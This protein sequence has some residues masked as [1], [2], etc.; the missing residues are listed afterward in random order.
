MNEK[1]LQRGDLCIIKLDGFTHSDDG[2]AVV[3]RNDGGDGSTVFRKIDLSSYP[4]CG[5]FK[6]DS[7]IVNEGDVALIM[8]YIGRPCRISI[9]PKWLNYDVYEILIQGMVRQ[10]FRRNLYEIL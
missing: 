1:K 2:F 4:S 8:G 7:S 10:V 3:G 6:G 9:G 5:D